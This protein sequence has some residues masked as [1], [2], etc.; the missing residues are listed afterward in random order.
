MRYLLMFLSDALLLARIAECRTTRAGSGFD[1]GG[2]SPAFRPLAEQLLA[3]SVS[4]RQAIWNEFLARSSREAVAIAATPEPG[5]G[6]VQLPAIL[7]AERT[8]QSA[9][10]AM[11]P[12]RPGRARR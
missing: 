9:A 12:A 5:P 10:A 6:L 4:D 8:D 7:P 3:A 11:A 2:A 1:P